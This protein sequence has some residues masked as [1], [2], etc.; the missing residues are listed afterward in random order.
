MKRYWPYLIL[1]ALLAVIVPRSLEK[2]IVVDVIDGDTLT[3][4]DKGKEKRVRL[5]CIDAPEK[6]QRFGP[7]ATAFVKDMVLNKSVKLTIVDTDFYGREIGYIGYEGS[8]LNEELVKAGL[9]WHYQQ[10]CDD[11]NYGILE[12]N[13]REIRAGLWSSDFVVSPWNFRKK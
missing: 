12:M 9:A 10:Y 7:E 8:T 3:V 4:L 2:T 5:G 13:A 11:P 6:N 1:F